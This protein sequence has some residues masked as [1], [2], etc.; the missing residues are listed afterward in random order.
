MQ[1]HFRPVIRE[2][3]M[4]IAHSGN[5]DLQQL[6]M[7]RLFLKS[8]R[9]K[10]EGTTGEREVGMNL[11]SGIVRLQVRTKNGDYREFPHVGK[12]M[13]VF[14]GS[15]AMIYLP[16]GCQYQLE[17]LH[18]PLDAA[19]YSA[20]CE[21][22]HEPKVVHTP[23]VKTIRTGELNWTRF[24]RQG[25]AGNVNADRLIMGET[26]TP[27]GN[28]TSFPPHKHDE[29]RPPS[30]KPAEEIYSFHFDPPQGFGMIRLYSPAGQSGAFDEPYTVLDGDVVTIARGYHPIAVAPG[31][32]CCYL[33]CLSGN[34]R[35]YGAW[36]DDPNHEW[37]RHCEMVLKGNE[38]H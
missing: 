18:G 6:D 30:E 38:L 5:S 1:K 33:F 23:E 8:A 31:Y 11:L 22:A 2:G 15:P 24:V 28:W 20:P 27:S 37:L 16:A 12:R 19:V 3:L 34:N 32:Q 25:I 10:Y 17:V 7:G 4:M 35:G 14:D 26:L 29:Y 13:S 21:V 36:S 9:S